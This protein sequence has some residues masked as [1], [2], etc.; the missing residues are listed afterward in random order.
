MTFGPGMDQL[1]SH[2]VLWAAWR[3]SG[4]AVKAVGPDRLPDTIANTAG[5]CVPRRTEPVRWICATSSGSKAPASGAV[6]R[7]AIAPRR[8]RR[9]PAMQASLAPPERQRRRYHSLA[10]TVHPVVPDDLSPPRP[11]HFPGIGI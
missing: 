11:G 5:T 10:L 6:A 4:Q 7:P 3:S 9:L 8:V 1:A 2:R